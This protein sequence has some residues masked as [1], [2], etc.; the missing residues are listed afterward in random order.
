MANTRHRRRNNGKRKQRSRRMRKRGGTT[1]DESS[2]SDEYV[3]VVD[4]HGVSYYVK[5]SKKART[6]QA[7]ASLATASQAIALQ[8]TAP[9]HYYHDDGVGYP[10]TTL[11]TLAR[12]QA[13]APQARTQQARAHT[14]AQTMQ[15]KKQGITKPE[16]DPSPGDVGYDSDDALQPPTLRSL[17]D[18]RY[19]DIPSRKGTKPNSR[20]DTTKKK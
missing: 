16:K 8:A 12:H 10:A 3:R 14:N 2:D 6:E 9:Q 17:H 15:P 7:T 4:R 19:D 20:K 18:R 11:A 1:D 13:P 5:K